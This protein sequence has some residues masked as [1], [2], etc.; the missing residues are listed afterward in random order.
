[1]QPFIFVCR[2]SAS[3]RHRDGQHTLFLPSND[4][5]SKVPADELKVYQKNVTAL[6]EFLLYHIAEGIHYSHD[7]RDGQYLKSLNNDQ[8]IRVSVNVDGCNRRLYEANNSPLYRADIPAS[9]GVVHVIDWVL[10]PGDHK[11]CNGVVLP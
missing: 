7:L 5:L 8:P 2:L 1:M 6:K 10:L 4:A 11:W 9:N 3:I